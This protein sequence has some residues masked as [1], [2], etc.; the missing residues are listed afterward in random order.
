MGWS[1]LPSTS[2]VHPA[3]R[4]YSSSRSLCKTPNDDCSP[5]L[6]SPSRSISVLLTSNSPLRQELLVPF[7]DEDAGLLKALCHRAG[8]WPLPSQDHLVVWIH[9][10]AA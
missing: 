7:V 5:C 10:A 4:I 2:R 6:W 1:L 8:L 9:L 3:E